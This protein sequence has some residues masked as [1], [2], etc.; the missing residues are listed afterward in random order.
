MNKINLNHHYKN[1]ETALEGTIY[2]ENSKTN[3]YQRWVNDNELGD[4]LLLMEG[5]TRDGRTIEELC[6]RLGISKAL[7]YQLKNDHKD[8]KRALSKGKEVVDTAVENALLK[9]ALEGDVKAMVFWLRNRQ[10]MKWKDVNQQSTVSQESLV[11]ID[12]GGV[13]GSLTNK[14]VLTN[15]EYYEED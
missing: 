1:E 9:K 2:G 12:L 13:V 15:E 8:I 5:Y 11:T 4:V 6:N 7:L 3:R 14:L 10:P